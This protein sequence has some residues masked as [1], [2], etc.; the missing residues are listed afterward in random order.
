MITNRQLRIVTIMNL[1]RPTHQCRPS[2]SLRFR[3]GVSKCFRRSLENTAP[4]CPDDTPELAEL[5]G[6]SKTK[7][8]VLDALVCQRRDMESGQERELGI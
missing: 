1:I 5:H 8:I 4:D 6:R 2:L 7:H 3:H